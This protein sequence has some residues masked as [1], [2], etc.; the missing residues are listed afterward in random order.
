MKDSHLFLFD[1]FTPGRFFGRLRRFAN[2]CPGN[3]WKLRQAL[4][5]VRHWATHGA[6]RGGFRGSHDA[7]GIC[8]NWERAIECDFLELHGHMYASDNAELTYN[9]VS[10]ICGGYSAPVW[11]DI[12][13][14]EGDGLKAR[15]IIIDEL[16]TKLQT[17]MKMRKKTE[18]HNEVATVQG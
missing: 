13:A 7:Y 6:V 4:T 18:A 16:D 11:I 2:D 10:S 8:F 9:L 1:D 15:L 12:P 5:K 3:V 14:W 17:F